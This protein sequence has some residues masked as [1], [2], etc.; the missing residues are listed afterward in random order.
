MTNDWYLS[1]LIKNCDF[2]PGR[3]YQA[4][5]R[6]IGQNVL[7]TDMHGVIDYPSRVALNA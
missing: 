2:E 6:L 3:C 7:W 1:D 5:M 4:A